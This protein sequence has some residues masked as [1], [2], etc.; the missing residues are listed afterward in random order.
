MNRMPTTISLQGHVSDAEAALLEGLAFER[1]LADLSACFADVFN[2]DFTIKIEQSLSQVVAFLGYDRCTFAELVAGHY[3]DVLCS[4]A[5]RGFDPL[6]RGRFHCT[7]PWFFG[8]LRAGRIVSMASL[9]ENLP[10][11]ASAEA[12]HC[13]KVGLRSY[14]S[15]PLRIG[16]RVTSVLSFAA[17]ESPRR[18]PPEMVAR[19]KIVGELLGSAMVLVR[20]EEEARQLRRRVWHADRVVR[21]SALTSA[22]AH[23]LNQPLTAILSNAQAGLN[24]LERKDANLQLVRHKETGWLYETKHDFTKAVHSIVNDGSLRNL[25]IHQA[26]EWIAQHYSPIKETQAYIDL[27]KYVHH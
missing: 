26:K 20:T 4:A 21:V 3:I 1:L 11:E 24:Y 15:I 8:E 17:F 19:L 10:P 5:A 23:Q 7:L 18:C 6:P 9:P 13:A 12:V 16:G 25:V 27:Y 22:I 14:L 2:C